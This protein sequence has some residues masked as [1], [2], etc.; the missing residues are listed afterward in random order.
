MIE[1][2]PLELIELDQEEIITEHEKT[3]Y[4]RRTRRIA[5]QI[6]RWEIETYAT[7]IAVLAQLL[8]SGKSCRRG[9]SK[10]FCDV[11]ALA[12]VYS[13]NI[14]EVV[15]LDAIFSEKR[16]WSLRHDL[17]HHAMLLFKETSQLQ[18]LRDKLP[19][20]SELRRKIETEFLKA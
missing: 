1:L 2:K 4:G 9:R 7:A 8:L 5:R 14:D 3:R 15:A 10:L 20:K 13:A 19:Q 18:Q 6:L 12:C 17:Y 11:A 16:L